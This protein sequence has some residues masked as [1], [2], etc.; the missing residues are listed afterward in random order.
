MSFPKGWLEEEISDVAQILV[1][2]DLKEDS[3]SEVKTTTHTFP[4]Y[5][6]S[7][8]NLGLYGFYDFEEYQGN[9]V[10]VVGRGAG[11]GTAFVRESGFGA[12][13]RL[14]VIVPRVELSTHYFSEYVN[15]RLRI[16]PES[17]GIPQL[18]GEQFGRYKI[19]L[20]PLSEQV[21]ISKI[22]SVWN[23]AIEKTERLIE[24][25]ESLFSQTVKSMIGDRCK[26]WEHCRIE[27]IFE[28]ISEKRNGD[29]ELLSVTQDRGVIPRNMLEGRVMSPEAGTEAY[30]LIKEGDFA[31]S[32]RS[33]Q[34][35]I[36]YSRYTGLISPAYTVLR[37]RL[38]IDDEFYMQF[39]KCKFF[40]EKY[41]T[42]VVIGIRD[43]KQISIPDLMRV[44]IPDPPLEEQKRIASILNS[45]QL[46]IRLLEKQAE[47]LRK[48]KRGL[49][50]KLLT[51]QWRVKPAD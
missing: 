14:L 26:Y 1:G 9:C 12:I 33:F 36:E 39:F 38:E 43:G 24:A 21:A 32:L 40:I 19:V 20:P 46:E 4:V 15:H 34:G 37:A 44:K 41:L 23:T 49:M 45:F 42:I 7:V 13:G 28:T 8:E 51:G 17:S 47:A 22:L 30:K 48:Q 35:G 16:F 11:L 3:F 18:P 2:R 5:S 6:N 10:T 31:V 50:Q 27:R 29:A 25:K